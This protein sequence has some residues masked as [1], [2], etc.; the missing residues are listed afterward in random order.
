MTSSP[1]K[2]L[3]RKLKSFL[4]LLDKG[5]SVDAKTREGKGAMH[6]AATKVFS[7]PLLP[8]SLSLSPSFFFL[9]SFFLLSLLQDGK[10]AFTVLL[11]SYPIY[12]SLPLPSLPLS[13]FSQLFPSLYLFLPENSFSWTKLHHQQYH[14]WKS[15]LPDLE[16]M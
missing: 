2:I 14:F 10:G 5:V 6:C 3:S 13:H 1:I 11:S 4:W 8:L 7:L 15:S 12:V 16:R 9:S